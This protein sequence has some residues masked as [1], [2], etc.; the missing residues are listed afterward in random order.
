MF[1]FPVGSK[2]L[3]RIKMHSAVGSP[4]TWQGSD[5]GWCGSIRNQ[6][7]QQPELTVF[8]KKYSET[9]CGSLYLALRQRGCQ[10][11]LKGRNLKGWGQISVC[12]FPW[13][14]DL[15]HLMGRFTAREDKWLHAGF[16]EEEEAFETTKVCKQ[17]DMEALSFMIQSCSFVL[18]PKL[19]QVASS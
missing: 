6:A 8:Q 5:K 10:V 7:V 19:M 4:K 13:P 16:P 15:L 9:P 1:S 17:T 3:A 12:F 2:H 14:H 11:L 18:Q